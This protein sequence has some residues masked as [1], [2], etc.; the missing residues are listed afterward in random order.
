MINALNMVEKIHAGGFDSV[1]SSLYWADDEMISR[2]RTRYVDA[3]A[4]AER[5]DISRWL[6]GLLLVDARSLWGRRLSCS[7]G[8]VAGRCKSR[9]IFNIEKEVRECQFW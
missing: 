1:F 4:A 2:Q 9:M 8:K 7:S 6:D 5:D 3:I